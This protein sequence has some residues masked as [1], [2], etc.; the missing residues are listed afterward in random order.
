MCGLGMPVL[1][2]SF[3]PE[4]SQVGVQSLNHEYFSKLDPTGPR[5]NAWWST[6]VARTTPVSPCII[7]K[8][9][10]GHDPISTQSLPVQCMCKYMR[11]PSGRY[12]NIDSLYAA[13]LE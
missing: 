8:I 11:L 4:C 2:V 9:V 1:T 3:S 6:G 5:D 13:C 7:R 12:W 10:L